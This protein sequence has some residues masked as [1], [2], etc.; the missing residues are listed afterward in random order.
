MSHNWVLYYLWK[1]SVIDC[2]ESDLK[3]GI[4]NE[5]LNREKEADFRYDKKAS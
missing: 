2:E 4:V 5:I 1:V 3:R